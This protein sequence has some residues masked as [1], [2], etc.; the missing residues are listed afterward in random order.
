MDQKNLI[1]LAGGPGKV[2]ET[3]KRI[4]INCIV[5]VQ[6]SF[7]VEKM[8]LAAVGMSLPLPKAVDETETFSKWALITLLCC[9][10]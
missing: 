10:H 4:C 6:K 8:M 3:K 5:Y 2:K 1:E 9:C 7:V